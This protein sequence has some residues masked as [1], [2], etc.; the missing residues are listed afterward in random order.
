[1]ENLC[2]VLVSTL[3]RQTMPLFSLGGAEHICTTARKWSSYFYTFRLLDRDMW[4]VDYSNCI[5]FRFYNITCFTIYV[6]IYLEYLVDV[7]AGSTNTNEKCCRECSHCSRGRGA[8]SLSTRTHALDIIYISTQEMSTGL[9]EI[10]RCPEK[11]PARAKVPTSAV[12]NP[13]LIKTL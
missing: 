5:V 10:L 11:A 2:G 4:I 6:S 9:R 1:M 13:L 7:D 8:I 12:K 3:H